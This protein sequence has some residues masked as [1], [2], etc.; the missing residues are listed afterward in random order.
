MNL[1][2]RKD[3]AFCEEVA[4]LTQQKQPIDELVVV[5]Q[6]A[7]EKHGEGMAARAICTAIE[8]Y[9]SFIARVGDSFPEHVR[10]SLLSVAEIKLRQTIERIARVSF[11]IH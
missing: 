4:A 9:K 7:I 11:E 6:A 8:Q 2:P 5:I 10:L 3:I 1:P